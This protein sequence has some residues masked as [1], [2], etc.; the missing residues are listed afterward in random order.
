MQLWYRTDLH[1]GLSGPLG[2]YTCGAR[3]VKAVEPKQRCRGYSLGPQKQMVFMWFKRHSEHLRGPK[4]DI[5]NTEGPLV[6][7]ACQTATE[8]LCI[9][10]LTLSIVSV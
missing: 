9:V 1:L 2:I 5:I 8:D 7:L 10:L 4:L 3:L 6:A